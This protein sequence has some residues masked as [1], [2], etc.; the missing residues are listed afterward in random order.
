MSQI[1][2]LLKAKQELLSIDSALKNE[3][4]SLKLKQINKS[5]AENKQNESTKESQIMELSKLLSAEQA[6]VES[7]VKERA[8]N[9]ETIQN[10]KMEM[11]DRAIEYQAREQEHKNQLGR[12]KLDYEQQIYLLKQGNM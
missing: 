5:I 3:I 10:L 12:V 8:R 7:L 6:K 2:R 4:Q 1:E 11:E 9:R